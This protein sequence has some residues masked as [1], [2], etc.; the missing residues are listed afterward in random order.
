M[1]FT[2]REDLLF[3]GKASVTNGR[4]TFKFIVPK[5]ITYSF[6]KGRITYFAN[7]QET[8]AHG[9]FSDFIVG[10]TDYAAAND[11]QGPDIELYMND[12]LFNNEGITNPDP[13]I[14]AKISD[15]S[16]INTIGNGIGHDITGIVDGNQN[17]PII[18]NDYFVANLDDNTSGLLTYQMQNLTEGMHS[19]RVKV[20]DVY[21]N[22]SDKTIEFR[23]MPGNRIIISKAF[24]YPN[25]AMDHTSFTFEHNR[26]GENLSMTI[27]IFDLQ[28]R[29]ITDIHEGINTSG[30]NYTESAWDLK[31][32]NGNLL[33]QGIYLYR[34]RLADN[35]GSYTDSYQK[36]VVV[37]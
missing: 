27:S 23:V 14:Y 13:L 36:L 4:F 22:S 16:G 15:K 33:K 29:L 19:L 34:I 28:G 8:D 10:G 21:N 12:E 18:L 5:D 31:D 17:L 32:A 25:P 1:Q 3:K 24:N 26:P 37:R 6:G 2:T 9:Q 30:F 35:T 7:D 20:W 11:S